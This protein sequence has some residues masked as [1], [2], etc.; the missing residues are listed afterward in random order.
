MENQMYECIKYMYSFDW[1]S[2]C[3]Q[4]S[5]IMLTTSALVQGTAP[6]N[7]WCI[8]DQTFLLAP[9]NLFTL[10]VM[11]RAGHLV[12]I[13][14]GA[15]IAAR[16]LLLP[17]QILIIEC[18]I[19]LHILLKGRQPV[20]MRCQDTTVFLLSSSLEISV[21]HNISRKAENWE[22]GMAKIW[23]VT[24]KVITMGNPA[25]VFISICWHTNF[26]FVRWN[27]III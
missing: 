10:Q 24:P 21:S 9:W 26:V 12:E 14:T 8:M 2:I 25:C 15:V 11:C 16:I 7:N 3:I 18:S 20:G 13:P 23:L 22:F 6:L 27:Y 4:V 17:S 1:R 5:G 19:L